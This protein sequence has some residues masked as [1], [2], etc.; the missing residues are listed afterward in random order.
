MKLL[1]RTGN[2]NIGHAIGGTIIHPG[3][4]FAA[5]SSGPRPS[6]AGLKALLAVGALYALTAAGLAVCGALVTAPAVLKLVPENYY[7]WEMIFALPVF[8][9][10]WLAAGFSAGLVSL[11]KGAGSFKGFLS[12]LGLALSV[13]TLLAWIPQA[14]LAVL[15]LLGR[16]QEEVMEWTAH[17]GIVQTAGL[18]CL[19]LAAAWM[20]V[21]AASAARSA[22]GLGPLRAAAVGLVATLIF[23]A[24]L[25]VFI[26]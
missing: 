18:L 10:A 8:V 25:L 16:K 17:P 1:F 2:M 21:L 4:T 20:F 5:V 12:A 22:R 14:V 15:L 11:G 13:P 3:R 9:L 23:L 6:A 24:G 26:R 19:L 7:F